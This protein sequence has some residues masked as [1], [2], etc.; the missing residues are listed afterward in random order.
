MWTLNAQTPINRLFLPLPLLIQP[1]LPKTQRPF[2]P[3]RTFPRAAPNKYPAIYCLTLLL[4]FFLPRLI[5]KEISRYFPAEGSLAF[6]DLCLYF[7]CPFGEGARAPFQVFFSLDLDRI[8]QQTCF[9]FWTTT[10]KYFCYCAK[11]HSTK[12]T[13]GIFH[14]PCM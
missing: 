9:N 14:R 2:K 12:R 6:P 7:C 1:S 3:E 4:A 11:G 10:M 5:V 8:R 13:D